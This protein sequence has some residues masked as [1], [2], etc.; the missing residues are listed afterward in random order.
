MADQMKRSIT[1]NILNILDAEM[2]H[3]ISVIDDFQNWMCNVVCFSS[4]YTQIHYS[5]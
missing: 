5:Q 3:T 4:I 1:L 2:L